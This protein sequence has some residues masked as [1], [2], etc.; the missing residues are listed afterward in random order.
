M[1]N[2]HLFIDRSADQ[3]GYRRTVDILREALANLGLRNDGIITLHNTRPMY[4][5]DDFTY[6]PYIA[7][8][9]TSDQ[10]TDDIINELR[11]LE[12]GLDCEVWPTL[13]HFIP[14]EEMHI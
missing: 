9:S 6:A 12:I 11:K 13:R 2:I 3:S 1:P 8:S 14:A 4:A 7:V 5:D 10:E